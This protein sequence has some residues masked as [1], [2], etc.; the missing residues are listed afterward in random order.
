L[1][2]LG[3][4]ILVFV[5]LTIIAQYALREVVVRGERVTASIR[6]GYRLFRRTLGRSLLVW[7]INL[8]LSIGIGIASLIVFLVLLLIL[9]GPGVLLAIADFTTTGIVVGIVGFV[10]FLIPAFVITGAIGAFSHSYWTL[11]Y[12]RLAVPPEHRVA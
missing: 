10:L 11:A 2:A 1:V 3:L 9:V 6:G 4:L 7:L 8:A 12:L 5:P